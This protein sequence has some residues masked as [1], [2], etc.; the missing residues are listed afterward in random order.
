[1]SARSCFFGVDALRPLQVDR[2]QSDLQGLVLDLTLGVH[3][4]QRLPQGPLTGA[5]HAVQ[6]FGRQPG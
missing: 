2:A 3:V 1:M 6:Q 5:G 4:S